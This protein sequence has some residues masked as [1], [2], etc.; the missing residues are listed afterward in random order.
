MTGLTGGGTTDTDLWLFKTDAAGV[1]AWARKYGGGYYDEGYSVAP[2]HGAGYIVGGM[3]SAGGLDRDLWLI[4]THADGTLDWEQVYDEPGPDYCRSVAMTSD[5]GYIATGHYEMSGDGPLPLIKTD[6]SGVEVWS[7]EWTDSYPQDNFGHWAAET[8]DGGFAMAGSYEGEVSLMKVG[9][10]GAKEWEQ[11]YG[12]GND[13][14]AKAAAETLDGGYIVAG[15][16]S[17]SPGDDDIYLVKTDEDGDLQW[18]MTFGTT[19]TYESAE[20]ILPLADGGYVILAHQ[21]P[22]MGTEFNVW[23]IKI[24]PDEPVED[25]G[26]V[27][28]ENGASLIAPPTLEWYSG[29]YDLFL[30]YTVFNYTAFGYYTV[31]FWHSDTTYKIPGPWWNAI[32]TGV[33]CYWTVLGYNSGTGAWELGAVWSFTKF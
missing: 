8:G 4:K 7:Q 27:S 16:I 32:A 17:A 3:T 6:G 10:S 22:L 13:G 28:P 5:G 9:A 29:D 30:L 21:A 31:S 12:G 15:V 1:P 23:L 20:A 18:E 2:A 33:P 19:S 11:S 25:F 24:G 26:L 14:R